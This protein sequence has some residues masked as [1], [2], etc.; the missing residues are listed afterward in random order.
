M[1]KRIYKMYKSGKL[2]VVAGVTIAGVSVMDVGMGNAADQHGLGFPIHLGMA[3]ASA[4]EYVDNPDVLP[5][6]NFLKNTPDS[7]LQWGKT[8]VRVIT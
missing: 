1:D 8:L 2:W 5:I 3:T 6:Q 7:G 4:S